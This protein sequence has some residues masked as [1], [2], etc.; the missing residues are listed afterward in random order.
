MSSATLAQLLPRLA[1]R[2]RPIPSKH[3]TYG[4]GVGSML[5]Q[6]RRRWPNI[7]PTSG[8][9]FVLMQGHE[10]V[11]DKQEKLNQSWASVVDGW[12]TLPQHRINTW[13]LANEL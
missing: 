11:H 5:G 6:R 10:C 7:D 9:Y 1:L 4:P 12:P 13:V 8:S 2:L 3:V